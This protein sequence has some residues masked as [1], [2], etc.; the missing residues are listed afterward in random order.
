MKKSW[1]ILLSCFS[2]G[3]LLSFSNSF[4]QQKVRPK[5]GLTLSGGGAKGLAHIGILKAIDSAGLKIDYV[6]GTSMGSIIGSLYAIGNSGNEIEQIA[7]KTDWSLIF[8]NQVPLRSFSLEE[9]DEYGSI[10]P[11]AKTINLASIKVSPSDFRKNKSAILSYLQQLEQLGVVIKLGK[12][13][14]KK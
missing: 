4:A 13:V 1:P 9:K 3:I 5:I 8:S 14:D 2:V 6:T 7:R 10:K 11:T 12:D